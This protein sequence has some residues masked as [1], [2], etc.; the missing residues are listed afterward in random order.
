MTYTKEF[1]VNAFIW[2]YTDYLLSRS[3]EE[4]K[5]FT[6]MVN[7]HYDSVGKDIFRKHTSLDAN[8][9]KK[10]KLALAR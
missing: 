8:E 10:Y 9:V 7:S 1:L 5:A 4:Q 3:T 6:D 2:R